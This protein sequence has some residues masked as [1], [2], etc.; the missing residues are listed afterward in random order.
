MN[1]R[2][3]RFPLV[4]ALRAIAAIS[5]VVFHAA[6]FYG[7][8]LQHPGAWRPLV[9]RL[10]VGVVVFLVISGFLLYRPFVAA[11]AHGRTPPATGAYA[12]RRFLRIVPPYWA[13]L[14]I[15]ALVLSWTYV[16]TGTGVL[17]YWLLGQVYD[18]PSLTQ[19]AIAPAWTL[20]LEVSFYAFLPCWALLMR[21]GRAHGPEAVL[22]R[23][24]R[25]V[26]LLFA[27]S[28][29]YKAALFAV[30]AVGHVSSAPTRELATL[31]GYLDCFAVGMGL[32]VASVWLEGRPSPRWAR[33]LE[34]RPG[35]AWGAAGAAYLVAAAV[36]D[37]DPGVGYTHGEYLL[38][39]LLYGVVGLGLVL[40]AVVGD[41]GGG[42]V[43]R[44]MGLRPLL[45][46]GLVSYG[47]YLW[48]WPAL[49]AMQH[50]GVRFDGQL[51]AVLWALAGV[52]AAAALGGASY[53]LVERPS[54]RLKRLVG[55][56]G[57]AEA[58]REP[59]PAAPGRTGALD[60]E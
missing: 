37:G 22:R 51:R 13:A 9:A 8:V 18:A 33:I 5:V 49:E 50:A 12:W 2:A 53:Y 17:R 1:A 6:G 25:A 45:W 28:F 35:A 46:L 21:S 20:G 19:G 15:A 39:T 36:L 34:R 43:R 44:L 26:A 48:H 59:A 24:A 11:H 14:L 55:G 27:A 57:Q 47:V 32:A 16:F 30:G 3:R 31:P 40:P 52:S 7:G 23:H 29:G 56:R 38:R 41:G 42:A 4:D 60:G 10:E 58:L 54:L